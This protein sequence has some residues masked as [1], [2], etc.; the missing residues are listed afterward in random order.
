MD[1][2]NV[3]PKRERP[4]LDHHRVFLAHEAAE[5]TS[6]GPPPSSPMPDS[7]R[8]LLRSDSD[9]D[10]HSG[11]AQLPQFLLTHDD[12]RLCFSLAVC[13]R[14]EVASASQHFLSKFFERSPSDASIFAFSPD[15]DAFVELLR[16]ESLLATTPLLA[17]TMFAA[18]A[19]LVA[20]FLASD[21]FEWFIDSIGP[22]TPSLL[23]VL[24]WLAENCDCLAACQL[25]ADRL[26]PALPDLCQPEFHDLL[27]LL[28]VI[29]A[30]NGFDDTWFNDEKLLSK[31]L[32][33]YSPLDDHDSRLI[34]S[35][36]FAMSG[37]RAD[38]A[39][40][41][42]AVDILD[43]LAVHFRDMIF[44]DHQATAAM[45]L[46]NL[47][48]LQPA[49][50]A[51]R[52]RPRPRRG[53]CGENIRRE[54]SDPDALLRTHQGRRP[55]RPVVRRAETGRRIRRRAGGAVGKPH[56]G[57]R[58]VPGRTPQMRKGDDEF[59]GMVALCEE[60][61]LGEILD[62][63]VYETDDESLLVAIEHFEQL[64]GGRM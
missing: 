47:F 61:N 9:S 45:L 34:L 2:P 44:P 29:I 62:A 43:F 39:G 23:G 5:L 58:P 64:M 31:F 17:Q 55:L 57:R 24:G 26:L 60:A 7:V 12:V 20:A 21:V 16:P 22:D 27:T 36:L 59:E 53:T 46:T 37:S 52:A 54:E 6:R 11:I 35:V 3:D 25:V 38:V 13:P 33:R 28:T 18:S 40:R 32:T 30:S 50:P 19:A 15:F 14:A 51:L 63:I 4:V 48:L 42:F 8:D 10:V 56:D 1:L 41:L 49:L